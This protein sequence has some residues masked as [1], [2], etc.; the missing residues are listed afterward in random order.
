MV[1]ENTRIWVIW[2][3]KAR[4]GFREIRCT[5]RSAIHRTREIASASLLSARELSV[6]SISYSRETEPSSP[7]LVQNRHGPSFAP[8]PLQLP[9]TLTIV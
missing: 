9:S 3:N 1:D 5:D 2:V 6:I 4:N 8:F 7:A